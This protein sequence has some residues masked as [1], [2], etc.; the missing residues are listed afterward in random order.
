MPGRGVRTLLQLLTIAIAVVG[1]LGLLAVPAWAAGDPAVDRY[2]IPDPVPTWTTLSPSQLQQQLSI[3]RSQAAAAQ[4]QAA[5]S[6]ASSVNS[7][8][9]IAVEEWASSDETSGLLIALVRYQK[10]FLSADVSSFLDEA[11]ES[12]CHPGAVQSITPDPS[13]KSSEEALCIPTGS[14]AG[15]PTICIFW[16]EAN[17]TAMLIGYGSVAETAESAALAQ[18][19]AIPPTGISGDGRPIWL[20]VLVAVAVFGAGALALSVRRQKR[21]LRAA[22]LARRT[23]AASA[24]RYGPVATA[25]RVGQPEEN[26]AAGQR[27]G[28]PQPARGHRSGSASTVPYAPGMVTLPAFEQLGA[29]QRAA[30]YGQGGSPHPAFG[31]GVA[32]PTSYG[33]GA[34][35]PE[36]WTPG[37]RQPAGGDAAPLAARHPEVEPT[38]VP[39]WYPYDGD[40]YELRYFDGSSWIAHKRWDGEAWIDVG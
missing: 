11:A 17:A 18:E 1:L 33:L 4:S 30:A 10:P 5:L 27:R 9:G 22:A 21:T 2:I 28:A 34:A 39:G 38:A 24:S 6:G 7:P 31:Q 29:R 26:G 3:L 19:Q 25:A 35:Q 36:V 15:E 40:D 12:G 14:D 8:S 32:R 13:I 16:T 20:I 37:G 23:K